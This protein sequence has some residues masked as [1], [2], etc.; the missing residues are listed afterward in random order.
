[1]SQAQH[2]TEA[3]KAVQSEKRQSPWRTGVFAFATA[4]ITD[5]VIFGI[6]KLAGADMVVTPRGGRTMTVG[7]GVI[8]SALFVAIA[9]ATLALR[10]LTAHGES[11][12]R[13]LAAGG[14]AVGLISIALVLTAGATVETKIALASM[15]TAAGLIWFIAVW[16]PTAPGRTALPRRSNRIGS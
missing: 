2:P 8:V 14:L 15:H 10:F 13:A 6:A 11:R 9:I 4:A 5:L 7:I 16:R 3:T 12:R 1:M